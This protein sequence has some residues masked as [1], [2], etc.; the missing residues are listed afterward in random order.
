MWTPRN[1]K[2]FTLSTGVLSMV[3][4]VC[5]LLCLLKPITSSLVLSMLSERWFSWHSWY[6]PPL[7]RPS[8]Q[9][10]WS[11]LSPLCRQQIWRWCWICV[12]LYSYVCTGSTGV[13]W[14]CSP[15]EHQCWGSGEMRYCCPFWPPDFC[16][17]GS[18][19]SICTEI[20]L[21][22]ESGASQ[23]VWQALWC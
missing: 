3:M 17:S 16:L 6:S 7:S 15:A 21:V 20:C 5:S 19:G 22:P 2:R 14:E 10:Q 1:L 9:C 13:G 23:P 12:W 18:P 8:H 4:G 11:G